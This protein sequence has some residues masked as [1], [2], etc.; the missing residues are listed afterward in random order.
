MSSP[1]VAVLCA[2]AGIP[3]GA[4]L[5]VVIERTPDRIPL[6][7]VV[8]GQVDPPRSW[9]GVPVQPWLLRGGA[10]HPR[11]PRWLVVELVTAVVF[12]VLGLEFGRTEAVVPILV[13]GAALIAISFVDLE[14]YRIPDR[15]TFPAL[16]V[17]G[18][19]LVVV[20]ATLDITDAL[21]GAAIGAAVY[22]GVLLVAHLVS[23]RGMGFGDVKLALLMGMFLGW[24]GWAPD[25]Q[26]VGPVRLVL[27]ALVLGCVLGVVFGLAHRV[28]TKEREGFPFGP[29]LAIACLVVLVLA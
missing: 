4:F 22:F 5:N 25:E 15:I 17:S 21:L 26:V 6:R 20:S 16:A 28:L 7:A 1:G 14:H 19:G 24:L 11:Q 18:I 12:G 10:P 29:S 9:A 23:P 8:D 2:V 27:N 3:V 13:L